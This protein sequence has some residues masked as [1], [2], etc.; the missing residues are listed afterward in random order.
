MEELNKSTD[1]EFYLNSGVLTQPF[2]D[3]E[4]VYEK[5]M[6]DYNAK[7]EKNGQASKIESLQYW[8]KKNVKYS[9]DKKFR[10]KWKFGRTAK[11]IWESKLATGCT[12]YAIL[13]ATFARQI[14]IPTT[15]LHTAEYN[16]LLRLK[17]NEDFN[18]HY[19][20]SFCECYIDGKWILV[21]PTC[22][23]TQSEYNADKLIL[24]YKV[25]DSNLYIPYFR[26][27]DLGTKQSTKEHNDLMDK[28]CRDLILG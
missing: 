8:I 2:L 10:D 3:E 28:E 19:G 13:F 1:V 20:H 14:G 5:V 11:E 4:Y 9:D 16:W 6:K 17:N 25:G 12:D 26:G 24:D 21:D 27:L 7:L 23:T 15:L 18:I 22:C